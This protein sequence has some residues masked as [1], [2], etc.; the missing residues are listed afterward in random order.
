M[1][2]MRPL[3]LSWRSTTIASLLLVLMTGALACGDS[4][5][6]TNTKITDRPVGPDGTPDPSGF[7]YF[8]V[9]NGGNDLKFNIGQSA[10]IKV[11]LYDKRDNQPVK[12]ETIAFELLDST[13]SQA[14]LAARNGITSVAGEAEVVL[15]MGGEVGTLKVRATHPSANPVEF[16]VTIEQQ[17]TGRIETTFVNTA[18]TIMPLSDIEVMLYNNQGYSCSEFRPLSQQPDALQKFQVPSVAETVP[19]EEVTASERY[20][21]TAVARGPRGQR[22]AAGCV[23]DIR[24]DAA[25]TSRVEVA[26]QFIPINPVGR[27]DMTANWD[28]SKAIEDSGAIG[29]TIIRV[30][31]VFQDPGQAL[32]TEIIN[33]VKFAVGG[34]ISGAIDTFL[35]L[36]GLNDD[37]KQLI[38]NAIA[39]NS[40]LNNLFTAGRD[41]R[42]VV[43]NLEVK[44]E[45]I[46]GKLSSSYEFRGTDN[47]LGINLYWRQGCDRVADP[48]CGIIPI[49]ASS[50]SDFADLGILSSNWTGRVVAYDQLQVDQHP[51]TLRYGRLLIFVLNEVILPGVTNGQ[52]HSLSQAFAY[53]INC[54][55]IATGVT[56]SDGEICALG[57]CLYATDIANF[58]N[59]TVST[60]FGFA[61]SLVRNLE[62]DIGLSVGGD[63]KL[64]EEDSD[65]FV[66]KIEM[67]KFN[68]SVTR[69]DGGA[70]SQNLT[71]P[72]SATWSALK[73]DYN[74]QGN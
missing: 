68:G 19:F 10:P 67:G 9:A 63:A 21:I 23:E 73:V 39:N 17:P 58:C 47:W 1:M 53:W 25:Q 46:I 16:T 48:Q 52:A 13:S 24:I 61:D 31:N 2:G 34:V 36:T 11:F 6:T 51:I 14:G 12:E 33:L 55:G 62:F 5:A 15:R 72:V 66:D 37:F 30:L 18:P 69:Q 64:I 20:I 49:V 65:G 7:A 41:L 32:Y 70:N 29:S 60:V 54:Q 35:R 8:M 57:A 43:T 27:Y 28:F 3:A 38:N 50:G 44:S 42:E 40:T 71:S 4:E 45:L 56:G 22:A 59:S 26:L 74:V